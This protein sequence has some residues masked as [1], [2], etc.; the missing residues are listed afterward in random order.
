MTQKMTPQ[1][2]STERAIAK[3]AHRTEEAAEFVLEAVSRAEM[4]P[5]HAKLDELLKSGPKRSPA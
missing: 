5:E 1:N 4:D 3:R 2:K